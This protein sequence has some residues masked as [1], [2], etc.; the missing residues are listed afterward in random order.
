MF[1]E[2]RKMRKQT[3]REDAVRILKTEKRGAFG[4]IGDEGYPFVVP[5]N[6]W[7]DEENDTIYVHS[8]KIGHK[9]DSI[10]NCDKVCFTVWDRGYQVEDWSYYVSSV[11]CFGRARLVPDEEEDTIRRSL[12]ALG[13]RYF[14]SED[15]VD[16]EVDNAIGRVQMI[17]IKVEHMTGRLTHEK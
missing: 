3:S 9:V 10:R 1:R 15:E 17:A 14:P 13:M 5:V 11:V 2:M 4:M 16:Y 6:F 12:K 8:G 7:Y